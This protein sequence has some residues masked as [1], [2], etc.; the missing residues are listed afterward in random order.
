MGIIYIIVI[1]MIISKQMLYKK[2]MNVLLRIM[3]IL[4][5]AI[6]I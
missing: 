2:C 3:R 5:G 4:F 6:I 1:V